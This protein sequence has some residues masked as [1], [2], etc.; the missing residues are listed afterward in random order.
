MRKFVDGHK[1]YADTGSSHKSYADTGSSHKRYA[2]TGSSHKSYADTGSSHKSYAHTGSSHKRY[3]DTG[4]SHITHQDTHLT[5]RRHF[6]HDVALM[7][8]CKKLK[9][10]LQES[11][12]VHGVHRA[13]GVAPALVSMIYTCMCAYGWKMNVNGNVRAYVTHDQNMS[14]VLH[15]FSRH[16]FMF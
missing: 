13:C 1:R 8:R 16:R 10:R 15:G 3:A 2:D 9:P 7:H 11:G 12:V 14:E 4:S 5:A 6:M